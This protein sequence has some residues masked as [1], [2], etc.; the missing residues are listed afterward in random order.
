MAGGALG[1]TD[2]HFPTAASSPSPR[3]GGHHARLSHGGLTGADTVTRLFYGVP[4]FQEKDS[5]LPTC[6][7]ARCERTKLDALQ[8]G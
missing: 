4:G 7:K 2:I 1:G 5:R 6:Q 3:L 8:A